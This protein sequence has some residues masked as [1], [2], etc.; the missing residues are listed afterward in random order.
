MKRLLPV[1]AVLGPLLWA[2]IASIPR[3]ADAQHGNMP[4]S[5]FAGLQWTF[6]RI[7]YNAWTVPRGGYMNP[8]D[9]PWFID[10]PAAE[11]NLSR[12]VRTA[13]AIQVN[14]PVVLTLEDPNLWAYPW[15]Y[16]VEPGNLRLKEAEV[17]ILREFLLRGGTLTFDDFHG[18]IEWANLE[19]EL[20][21]VFP[22]RK[23]ID[24]PPTEDDNGRAMVLINWNVDMGDGWEWS[25]ASDF[26]GYVKYTAVAYR[27][28]INEII[29][30][31]T[32]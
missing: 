14:D 9:E 32:H 18:P 1:A 13:T 22:D 10:A 11:Q 5:R 8:E 4:D 30:S 19:S 15:I 17:P 24:L 26:P 31:L 23:I 28:E 16:M 20:K 12:R 6:V 2:G 27:M 3:P 21:R 7:R 25:N 29:Y